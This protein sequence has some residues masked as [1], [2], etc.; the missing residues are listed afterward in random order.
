MRPRPRV[1]WLAHQ[2]LVDEART[3]SR[4]TW[5]DL[6]W[7]GL[8]WRESYWKNQKGLA[9]GEGGWGGEEGGVVVEGR[10]V[11]AGEWRRKGILICTLLC[12]KE[13]HSQ[14]RRSL[15]HISSN[16]TE[17]L[18]EIICAVSNQITSVNQITTAGAPPPLTDQRVFS[19]IFSVHAKE[20]ITGFKVVVFKR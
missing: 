6:R 3:A 1:P 12:Q 9:T 17:K 11:G 19:L 7:R 16:K 13:K 2:C 4:K 14:L 5:S 15:T 18:C 8:E 10:V 20:F